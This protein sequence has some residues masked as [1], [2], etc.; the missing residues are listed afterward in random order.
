M[1]SIVSGA[2]GSLQGLGIGPS[3]TLIGLCQANLSAFPWGRLWTLVREEEENF[4]SF[5]A[6]LNSSS[7]LGGGR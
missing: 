6:P 4:P 5:R 2:T 7:P 3:G 1:S